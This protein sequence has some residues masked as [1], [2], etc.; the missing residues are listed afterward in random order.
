MSPTKLVEKF[1]VAKGQITHFFEKQ[2]IQVK[3]RKNPIII[4]RNRKSKGWRHFVLHTAPEK[5]SIFGRNYGMTG[6][7]LIISNGVL[8]LTM[9]L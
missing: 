3:L 9:D 6:E 5:I 8:Y 4:L 2:K 7:G 1:F